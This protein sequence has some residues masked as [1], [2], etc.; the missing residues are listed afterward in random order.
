MTRTYIRLTYHL[1]NG[2]EVDRRYDLPL[3]KYRMAQGDTYDALLNDLVNGEAMKAKR[4]HAGDSR[5]T[6]ESGNLWLEL[7]SG[8]Y[9]LNSRESAAILDAVAR[10]AASGTWGDYDWFDQNYDSAY[11]IGLE[12]RFACSENDHQSYD[13]IEINVRP[14]MVNTVACLKELGLITDRDLVTREEMDKMENYLKFGEAYET[15]AAGAS[16]GIIGGADGPT[17]VFVTGV[18]A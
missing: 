1:S 16:I 8:N 10:D 17:T 18:T 3:T 2:L 4:L 11:A 7:S 12:L 9:D 6:V 5:Y 13:W 15:D 14:G